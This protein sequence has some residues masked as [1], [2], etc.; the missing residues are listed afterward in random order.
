MSQE[1]KARIA[2][3]S[4]EIGLDHKLPTY[5][6]G[7]GVLAGDSLRA[8]ADLGLPLVAVSLLYHKGYFKQNLDAKGRQT[9]SPVEWDPRSLL[10]LMTP[11]VSVTIEGKPVKIKA[12]QYVITGAKGHQVPVYFLDTDFPE[13][14]P[15]HRVLANNLYGGDEHYRLCQ[16]VVL[17]LGGVA[18]L[19]AIGLPPATS[20]A[21][22]QSTG[23]DT[24]HMN[25]GHAALLTLGL[26]ERRTKSP[27]TEK[28]CSWVKER[29]IFTTH[30][31]VPAGHDTFPLDLVRQV[32]GD[33]LTEI[34]KEL[35]VCP[36]GRLNMT[37]LALRFS[38][39]VNGVAKRHGEVSRRMF[40]GTRIEAI[41]NGV[42]AVSWTADA[43]RAL[44]DKYLDGWREDNNYLRYACEIPLSELRT[45]HLQAKK[46]LFET[47]TQRTGQ[48]FDPAVLTIGFARRAA[49]YKRADLLFHDVK[50]LTDVCAGRKLQIVFG[51]KAHPK[52]FGGKDL[53]AK[54]HQSAAA[55][56]DTDIKVIY[57]ENYDMELGRIICSGVDIWL[58]NP[59][60]PLEASGTSGMKAA[61]NGVPNLSTLDGWWVEGW[62]EGITGW[63][64]L[65]AAD[66]FG[67]A[68]DS[69]E[70][71]DGTAKS[72]YS[73][74][75]QT[76]LPLYYEKPDAFAKVMRDSIAL[77][78]A[79]FNTHR[80]MI[81][82]LTQAY[83]R[84]VPTEARD[85][86][87][88]GT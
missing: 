14:A 8:A 85:L 42:H 18:Y 43:I 10:K 38:R 40:P 33:G 6:G 46:A 32:L 52:D 25:E 1:P 79:F 58:N 54:V 65:D 35:E 63:E 45:A 3:F 60:K 57:L 82:Y 34:I 5:S 41:T 73:L 53:I 24:Y 21:A 86:H 9:E 30:T 80:M 26:L 11:T 84:R 62:V 69:G 49:E 17:G 71:R 61:I 68:K 64:I 29:A 16:E 72:L 48:V 75:G 13:N 51:G 28:D 67:G 88:P 77:N 27:A 37:H 83:T 55:L 44:F 20:L 2:Y 7:L 87:V 81:Q 70:H 59:V 56:A 66:A 4:M 12:W 47:I 31:P 74:L 22:E 36:A 19:E 15:E 78:G 23:I 39:Y 50:Q 76:I